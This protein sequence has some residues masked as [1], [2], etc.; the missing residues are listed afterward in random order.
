MDLN[1]KN[2]KASVS[3]IVGA[4]PRQAAGIIASI[5]NATAEAFSGAGSKYYYLLSGMSVKVLA[6]PIPISSAK[7]G[8]QEYIRRQ[9]KAD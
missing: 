9:E 6:V 3:I 5:S 4:L 2:I 8:V 1:R 7:Q